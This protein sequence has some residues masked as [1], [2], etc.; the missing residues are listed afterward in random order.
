MDGINCKINLLHRVNVFSVDEKLGMELCWHLEIRH[1]SKMDKCRI[2]KWR[3]KKES[4]NFWRGC[5][6]LLGRSLEQN[7]LMDF[8][9][10][11]CLRR[12]S[13]FRQGGKARKRK[14]ENAKKRKRKKEKGKRRFVSEIYDLHTK[15]LKTIVVS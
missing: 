11:R 14:S 6:L 15:P 10:R 3:T 9:K 12:K 1:F 13:D 4:F 7:L 5:C 8:E 2:M